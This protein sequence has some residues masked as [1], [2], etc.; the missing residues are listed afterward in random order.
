MR[1]AIIG[2]GPS[3]LVTLKHLIT[4]HEFF[5]GA[6]PFEAK[7]FEA[8]SSIGGT[9]K[10]RDYEDAELVSSR[11]LTTFSD[12]RY[13][14][15]SPDFLST[16]DYC[17]YLEGYCKKFNL[18]PYIHLQTTV[19]G[20]HRG[21]NGGHTIQYIAAG[22][23]S[24]WHCD[25][26]AICSG[27]HVTPNIP[28]LSGLERVP[29]VIHSSQFKRRKQFGEGKDVLIV[30]SGETGMDLGYLAI[31]SKTNSVTL[32]HR[33]GFLCAPK[34]A[35]EPSWFG[36]KPTT[37]LQGNVPYDVGASSLFDTAYVHPLLQ[38]SFLPWWY[39]DRFAKWTTWLV[40]GTKAGLD[41]WIGEISPERFHASKIFFNKSTKAMPYITSQ[42]RRSSIGNTLRSYIA[43]VPLVPTHGRQID[44][45]PWPQSI[46][47]KGI[48]HFTENSRSEAEVMRKKICKPDVLVLATGYTQSFPFLNSMYPMPKDADMRAIWKKGEE[49]VAFIGFVRPSFGAIPPL[50]EMQ[51]QLW[52][53]SLLSRL[54]SPLKDTGHYKLHHRAGSR[55]TYGV[56]HESY[57]YQLALDIGSAPSFMEILPMGWKMVLC[58]AL[59]A[60]VNTKFRLVGPWK[61]DGAQNV[62]ETEIWDTVSRRRGFF[63]HFTLSFLPM[64]LFGTL[65]AVLWVFEEVWKLIKWVWKVLMLN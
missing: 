12:Y 43:Q 4:A 20:I 52:V 23:S 44:L 22:K 15:E 40:S 25:A 46:D 30:G 37:T 27:L 56:D 2:G 26:V 39:Y 38:D 5:P 28:L 10:H 45:A 1:V 57:A 59:S 18:W 16:K 11:Q 55:I 53:T 7:L 41:Q 50:A 24:E 65:S 60:Q 36:M 47:E 54:P 61:W 21:A 63:G 48:V 14:P 62:M 58:W 29:T 35:P 19:T 17:I 3:G 8:E 34:R 6:K 31:T 64:M 49:S 9:F 33:D 13:T 32:C 42:Y 51:A